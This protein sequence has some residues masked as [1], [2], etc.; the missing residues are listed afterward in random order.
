MPSS[1]LVDKPLEE[2]PFYPLLGNERLRLKKAFFAD[3]FCHE[4]ILPTEG[5]PKAKI[6]K[7]HSSIAK[8][9][10]SMDYVSLTCGLSPAHTKDVDP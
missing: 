7:L 5:L 10:S 9:T 2:S 3:P 4:S 6:S 1:V 8:G